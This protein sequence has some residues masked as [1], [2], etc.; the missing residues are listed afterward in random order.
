MAV[1]VRIACG[2]STASDPRSAAL[3]AAR[4]V[5]AELDGS[6]VDLA[7]V[8]A[9]GAHLAAP[10]ATLE[11]V[12][13][14]L[15]PDVLVGCGAGGVVGAGRE[16]EEG[17]AVSVWAGCFDDGA[18]STFHAEVHEVDGGVAISGMPELEGAGGAIILPDPYSFPTD[19][20]LT[21]LHGRAPGVPVLGGLSSA[22]TLDG[23]AALFL[24]ERGGRRRCGRRALR[25]RRAAAVRLAGRDADRAGADD[26]R[27]RG[28][29]HPRAGGQAGAGGA[30]RRRSRSSARASARSSA[31]ACS[32]AS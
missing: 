19:G 8:F 15:A 16:I 9:S 29:G 23:S 1:S 30:A 2:L 18:V 27:R 7:V 5:A 12:H 17:T 28:A 31:R 11:G 21:E 3:D 13:E 20:V 26:H 10:E 4:R 6:T 25:R 32:S 22:R 24:G 14:G